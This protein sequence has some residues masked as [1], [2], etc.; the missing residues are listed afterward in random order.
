MPPPQRYR[1]LD[2]TEPSSQPVI[3]TA[4]AVIQLRCGPPKDSSRPMT[5]STGTPIAKPMMND[6]P[7]FR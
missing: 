2:T 1:M 7:S 3:M 5:S 6:S 4:K